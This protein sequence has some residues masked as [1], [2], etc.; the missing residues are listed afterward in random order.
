MARM[1]RPR[2]S[3][4]SLFVREKENGETSAEA[5]REGGGPRARMGRG[6]SRAPPAG[7]LLWALALGTVGG[8][9]GVGV[10]LE[11]LLEN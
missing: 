9:F 8:T 1:E 10:D 7:S 4:A 11:D 2:Q 3:I 5:G 6:R